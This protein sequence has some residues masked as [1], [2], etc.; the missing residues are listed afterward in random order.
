VYLF[1]ETSTTKA[2]VSLKQFSVLP[3]IVGTQKRRLHWVKKECDHIMVDS[4]STLDDAHKVLGIPESRMTVVYPSV[5]TIKPTDEM[6]LMTRSTYNL[7]RPYILTVG[8]L[9]PR[10]NTI[11]LIDAFV[12]SNL[13][14][15]MDL[16]VVGSQ[17]WG[18]VTHQELPQEVDETIKFVGYVPDNELFALYGSATLFAMPSLYE[19]FGYPVIEAMA[20]GC[21]VA[22]SKTSSVGELV[23]GRGELF[24]PEDVD[25]ISQSLLKLAQDTDL[26]RKYSKKG[27]AFAK[28]FSAESFASKINKVF[29][30]L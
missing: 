10:K 29:A 24:D 4:K 11:R 7:K 6:I 5:H 21:P 27:S 19:G 13:Y 17:G 12:K 20:S 22:A 30:S 18:D 3:N 28:S 15:E 14:K 1:P 9:E 2:E 26:Q 25:D 16:V 23:R 8:K